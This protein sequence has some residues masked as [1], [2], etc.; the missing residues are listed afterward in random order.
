MQTQW[1]LLGKTLLKCKYNLTST[2]SGA[3]ENRSKRGVHQI[4]KQDLI[5]RDLVNCPR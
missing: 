2:Q 3:R 1:V 5:G 4:F